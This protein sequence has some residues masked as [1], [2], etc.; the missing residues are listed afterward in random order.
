MQGDCVM[1]LKDGLYAVLRPC[2]PIA[3]DTDNDT[4]IAER[5]S[6]ELHALCGYTGEGPFTWPRMEFTWPI[7]EWRRQEILI[8]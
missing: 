8:A 6:F 1:F 3:L 7:T 5:L 2:A 4:Q